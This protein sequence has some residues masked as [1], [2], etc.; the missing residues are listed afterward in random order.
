MSPA[1]KRAVERARSYIQPSLSC[2]DTIHSCDTEGCYHGYALVLWR[3]ETAERERVAKWVEG[4]SRER[5]AEAKAL[6]ADSE[7]EAARAARNL[8]N[9]YRHLAIEIRKGAGE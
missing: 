1:E 3:H 2:P 8:A 7:P 6:D 9:D 5:L 4:L